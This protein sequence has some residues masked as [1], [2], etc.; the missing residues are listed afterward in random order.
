MKRKILLGLTGSVAT[1]LHSKLIKQFSD[2]YDVDVILTESSKHFIKM[3]NDWWSSPFNKVWTDE[4][5][6]VWKH[7]DN[8]FSDIWEKNDRVLHINLRDNSSALVI[9]PCSANTLAKIANGISDNL[10]TT[11]ARAWDFN[12]PFIIAL[13]MNTTMYNNPITKE[14]IEKLESWGVTFVKP[15]TKKLACGSNGIGAMAEIDDIV[16]TLEEKLKWRFPL[17]PRQRYYPLNYVGI[18][19]GNHPGAFNAIRKNSIHTGVDLYTK[20]GTYVYPVEDGIVVGIEHFTG[21][22]DNSPWWLDTDC[23]L[24]EGASGVICYGEIVPKTEI[25]NIVK[26]GIND[27]GWV[28]RVIPEGKEHTEINGWLPNMLHMELYPHGVYKASESYE[29]DKNILMDPTQYLL[30]SLYAPKK[31]TI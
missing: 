2:I 14:H 25:G 17:H 3:D 27:I 19:V 20:Q 16:L 30:D 7:S 22:K 9:A 23:V 29:K 1:T 4:K 11:V 10:L 5:E 28:S 24:V 15:Q 26:K 8:Y 18:P 31:L 6:W 21:P 13:A 12:R